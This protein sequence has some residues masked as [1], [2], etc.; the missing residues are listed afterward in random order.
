MGKHLK[1]TTM[2]SFTK[3]GSEIYVE[4]S[5]TV[6]FAPLSTPNLYGLMVT[7]VSHVLGYKVAWCTDCEG[8]VIDHSSDDLTLSLSME[9]HTIQHKWFDRYPPASGHGARETLS[10][11]YESLTSRMQKCENER[12]TRTKDGPSNTSELFMGM[13]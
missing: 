10:K 4:D 11:M 13:H 12:R 8:A 6:F 5:A 3:L 1:G 2:S 7:D 9:I